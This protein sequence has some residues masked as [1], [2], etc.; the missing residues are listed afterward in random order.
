[1]FNKLMQR[2]NGHSVEPPSLAEALAQLGRDRVTVRAEIAELNARRTQAL[3]DDATDAELDR[4]ERQIDRANV[5]LEKLNLAEAPLR[6]QLEAAKAKVR[7]AAEPGLIAEFRAAFNDYVAQLQALGEAHRRHTE[8]R[9][10]ARAALGDQRAQILLPAF[11][12]A[13]LLTHEHIKDWIDRNSAALAAAAG[14]A[15]PAAASPVRRAPP[16]ELPAGSLQHAVRLGIADHQP[17]P[18]VPPQ[19]DDTEPLAPG[20]VR[21]VTIRGGFEDQAGIQH[22]AGHRFQLPAATAENAARAGA[23]EIL[24]GGSNV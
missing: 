8:I 4:I 23:V 16:P 12:Y 19:A 6:Q 10:R 21:V 18:K 22:R 17:A 11:V 20:Y 5:K 1:M 24:D 2:L 13:G 3:L 14:A 9:E 7:A 15:P